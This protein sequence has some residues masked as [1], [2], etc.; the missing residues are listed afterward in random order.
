MSGVSHISVAVNKLDTVEWAEARFEQ[1][2]ASLVPFLKTVGY[3]S[4]DVTYVPCSGLT[5]EN[6]TAPPTQRQL[7]D[8]YTGPSILLAIGS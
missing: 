4:S 1:I 2:K 7:T 6:L 8:W 5:G 3:R